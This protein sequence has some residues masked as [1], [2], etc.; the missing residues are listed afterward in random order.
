MKIFSTTLLLTVLALSFISCTKEAKT[1]AE[2]IGDKV[3]QVTQNMSENFEYSKNK[4]IADAENKIANFNNQTD[5]IEKEIGDASNKAKKEL[6]TSLEELKEQ[7]EE[8]NEQLSELKDANRNNWEK[9]TANI[10]S[11]FENLEDEY[12]DLLAKIKE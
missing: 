1:D 3:E 12:N 6:Q 11:G 10:Q 2:K 4:F 5:D 7:K 9:I 8:L